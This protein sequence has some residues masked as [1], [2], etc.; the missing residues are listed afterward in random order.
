VA[1]PEPPA[2]G[3]DPRTDATRLNTSHSLLSK[4]DKIPRTTGRARFAAACFLFMFWGTTQTRAQDFLW[5]RQL[6][7]TEGTE[8]VRGE[9]VAVDTS[10][11][12]Y[13]VGYFFGT[14]DFDPGPGTHNLTAA[15]FFDAFISKL[16]G[17]GNFVWARQLAGTDEVTGQAVAVDTGG[18]LYTVGYL[19]GA[20]DFDP[21]PGTFN[22][23]AAGVRDA[24]ILKLDSDG[25]FAWARQLGGTEDV[26]G[27]GVAVDAGGNVYTMGEFFGTADFDPGSGTYDLT[28]DES[29]DVFISK[30]DGTGNFVWARQLGGVE[31]VVGF[32]V[33]VDAGANVYT[34]GDFSG[35]VDFDPGPGAFNLTAADFADSAFISKLDSAGNFV[36][37]RQL[38]GTEGAAGQGVAVDAGG[39][40][41]TV[42]YFSGTVDFDPGPGTYNLIAAGY[43]D[44]F[45]SRLDSAGNFAWARQ[46]GGTDVVVGFQVAVDAGENV[47]TMG[48]FSGTADFDPGPGAYDLTAAHFA[49][50]TFISKLDSAGNFAWAL[51]MGGG[52]DGEDVAVDTSDNVYTV[53]VFSGTADFDPGPG[54]FNL[55]AAVADTFI[56]KLGAPPRCLTN[57]DCSDGVFCN[58]AEVC[59]VSTGQ[60]GP[61]TPPTCD[62]QSLCTADRC[63]LTRDA[64]V[65]DPAD[66]APGPVGSTLVGTHDPATGV[67]RLSWTE[68]PLAT[69]YNTYRGTIPRSGMGS[70]TSPYDHTCHESDDSAGNGA[71]VS[72][73]GASPPAG[74]A[75]YYDVSGGNS[76]GEGP[77]GKR[78]N[79]ETRPNAS[80]CPTPP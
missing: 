80:P 23:T 45:I 69:H 1:G 9:A 60:C 32:G 14:A 7:G 20:V 24:F 72:T 3:A 11:N 56:S 39:N 46:L 75:S 52:V 13:T 27:D 35:T 76:C 38:A 67:T 19:S 34:V 63:D 8:G 6:S 62:D 61:G 33:A 22:L 54:I 77:L 70:R 50:E 53:G 49:E 29:G 26:F 2:V 79:G 64:C 30:L 55:T 31:D 36:W 40:V 48:E 5:A 15:G 37:A 17:A 66:P 78:S 65:N 59:D 10:G 58:G 18:N 12:V 4:I 68:I 47:Y 28:T 16:D 74:T 73:D 42:G 51:Q 44:A 41:C 25:D 21:G 71:T 43:N 57:A